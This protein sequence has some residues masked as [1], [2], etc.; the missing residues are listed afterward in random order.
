MFS[1]LEILI[2]EYSSKKY[3]KIKI[4]TYLYNNIGNWAIQK[5]KNDG[6]TKSPSYNVTIIGGRCILYVQFSFLNCDQ[7]LSVLLA[8]LLF[9]VQ[10]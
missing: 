5:S 9:L 4:N 10:F 7:K 6:D 2:W 3:L 8:H 1:D